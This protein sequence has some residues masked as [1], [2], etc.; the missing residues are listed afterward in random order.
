MACLFLLDSR[1]EPLRRLIAHHLAATLP[2]EPTL[3]DLADHPQSR[4]PHLAN[5]LGWKRFFRDNRLTAVDA[6]QP[7]NHAWAILTAARLAH[8]KLRIHLDEPLEHLSPLLRRLSLSWA[9]QILVTHPGL[10]QTLTPY[11]SDPACLR[12]VKPDCSAPRLDPEQRAKIRHS[13]DPTGR[14]TLVLATAR[15]DNH[16]GLLP[17]F[18]AGALACHICSSFSLIIAG[19]CRPAAQRRI[20]HWQASLDAPGLVCLDPHTPF[21][22]LAQAA[23]VALVSSGGFRESLRLACAAEAGIP[24]IAAGPDCQ[25][26]LRGHPHL[27]LAPADKPRHLAATLLKTLESAPIR[28]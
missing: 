10:T 22:L 5:L 1:R 3:L 27:H 21:P 2:T 9:D 17:Q 18:W 15:P 4:H 16:L 14:R 7:D 25:R 24:I 13:L 8:A 28:R 11:L 6:F 20:E 23:D 19:R 12:V 26:L